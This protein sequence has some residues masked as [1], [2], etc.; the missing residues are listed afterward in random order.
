M[1][2]EEVNYHFHLNLASENA[3]SIVGFVIER[4]DRIPK[5]GDVI[6]YG[7]LI[8]TVNEMQGLKITKLKIKI[9]SEG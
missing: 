8:F 6:R 5:Q 7:D 3:D 1:R 2:I 4:L 9:G